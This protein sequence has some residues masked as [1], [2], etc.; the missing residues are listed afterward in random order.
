MLQLLFGGQIV[1]LAVD[2]GIGE[3]VLDIF[4]TA[5]QAERIQLLDQRS[6]FK[7][8]CVYQ[9]HITFFH[10]GGI[11]D[12][13]FGKPGNTGSFIQLFLSKPTPPSLPLCP[14]GY[15]SGEE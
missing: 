1:E 9:N 2:L 15:L 10:T 4:C 14:R 5:L 3:A 7:T 11:V 13:Y 8:G 12:Q 6:R